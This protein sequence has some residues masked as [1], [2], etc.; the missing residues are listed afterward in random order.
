MNRHGWYISSIIGLYILFAIIY[1]ICSHLKTEKRFIIAAV[2]L[3]CFAVGFR[4]GAIIADNGGMYTREMPAFAIGCIYAAFYQKINAL[5]AKYYRLGMIACILA[6]VGGFLWSEPLATY[7][8]ALIIIL[9]F[10]KY[11]YYSKPT[12]FLG[13][14][15]IGVYLFLHFSSLV[16]QSFLYNEYWWVLLNAGFIIELAVL[17]YAIECSI[18]YIVKFIKKKAKKFSPLAV[19]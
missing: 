3:S 1:F 14:I 17:L 18:S 19:E 13:K 8:A 5:A 12:F 2:I 11:T 7:A 9:V 4:V 16:L 10:Q 6:F 15:C